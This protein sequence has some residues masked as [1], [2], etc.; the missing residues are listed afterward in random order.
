MIRCNRKGGFGLKLEDEDGKLVRVRL[1]HGVNDISPAR[2]ADAL[3]R[4]DPKMARALTS[5]KSNGMPPDLEIGYQADDDGDEADVSKMSAADKVKV[6][7]AANS[8]DELRELSEGEDRK[9]VMEAIE[10]RAGQLEA[11]GKD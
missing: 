4:M 1:R 8:F 9:T 2:V 6:A 5:R 7:L 11:A 3:D 10:K